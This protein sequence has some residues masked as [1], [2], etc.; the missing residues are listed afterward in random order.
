[1]TAALQKTRKRAAKPHGKLKAAVFI[2]GFLVIATCV[3]IFLFSS[4]DASESSM[5]SGRFTELLKKLFF[6]GFDELSGAEQ[7][8]LKD[9]ITMLVRKGAHFSEYLIL[10]TFS[11]HLLYALP[12]PRT[13]V[14]CALGAFLFAAFFAMTDEFH[15][16]FVPGRAM[17]AR[18]VLIDSLGALLGVF[19]ALRLKRFAEKRRA[20]KKEKNRYS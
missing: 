19:I 18:D 16:S 2:F 11:F 1:M 5:T 14:M 3:M 7:N 20:R 10:A 12:R 4:Q 13:D 8:A 9:K 6:P 15:Q 17:A